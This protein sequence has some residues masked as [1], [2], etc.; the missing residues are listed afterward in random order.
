MIVQWVWEWHKLLQRNG[1][2]SVVKM[3]DPV[4]PGILGFDSILTYVGTFLDPPTRLVD[5]LPSL[6][7]VFWFLVSAWTLLFGQRNACGLQKP[8]VVMPKCSFGGCRPTPKKESSYTEQNKNVCVA[9]V[10]I[11][12]TMKGIWPNHS[13]LPVKNSHFIQRHIQV[14]F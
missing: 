11:D 1:C 7:A 9:S 14:F 13:P 6:Y 2:V 4:L 3:M 12:G 5:V 8:A 10:N